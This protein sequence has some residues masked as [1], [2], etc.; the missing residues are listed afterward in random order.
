MTNDSDTRSAGPSERR[1]T[2]R[3]AAQFSVAM[4]A[5]IVAVIASVV[6]GGLDGEDP[7]RFAWAVLPV[8]PIAWL[9]VILI[10]FVLGSDEFEFVQA[11]KG[12]AVGFVVTMLLAV[13]AGFLDIAGLSIPGLGWW[14]Y[15]GGMLAWLAATV[16]IRLR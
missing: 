10:R 3:F 5:Y 7:S 13:L 9:A 12:L 4:A 8:L 14:L 11:L 1:R 16:A 2:R 6:W 15:A